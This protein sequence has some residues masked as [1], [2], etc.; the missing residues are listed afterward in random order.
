MYRTII[1]KPRNFFIISD[2]NSK[3]NGCLEIKK[4]DNQI[5]TTNHVPVPERR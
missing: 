5:D 4:I 3:S 1:V 2:D